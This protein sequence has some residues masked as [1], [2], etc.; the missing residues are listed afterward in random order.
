MGRVWEGQN[1]VF[2]QK[3]IC[4]DG[5]VSRG[6]VMVQD[7]IAGMP[8]PKAMSAHS[9]AEALQDCFV[10][11]LIYRLSSRDVLMM[12]QPVNVEEHNQ[13]GLY[14]GLACLAFLVE[15][16]LCCVAHEK[17]LTAFTDAPRRIPH[18]VS[19]S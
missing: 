10:E 14:I 7:S 2:H 13:H 4:G 18:W 16:M 5:P 6:I 9:I 17:S 11:F 1:V 19:F 15:E 8:L 3:F 12:N